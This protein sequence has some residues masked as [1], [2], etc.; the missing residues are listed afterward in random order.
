MAELNPRD[1]QT[2]AEA[3]AFVAAVMRGSQLALLSPDFQVA[4]DLSE[5]F[6]I[7]ARDLLEYRR[8][9]ARRA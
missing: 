6:D 4:M 8:A 2:K 7:R 5:R 3:V 9:I 1:P